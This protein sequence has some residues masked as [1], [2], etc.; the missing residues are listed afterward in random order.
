M[1]ISIL[2]VVSG[3]P[4]DRA[5]IQAGW[6]VEQMN[7]KPVLDEIDYQALSAVSRIR[8][9]LTL[10]DGERKSVLLRKE[11]WEPLGLVLDETALMKPR[12]CR[13]HCT[14][15][16]IDQ[17]PCRMRDSLYVKD[18]DWRLSLMMG[19]YITLT[20]IDDQEFSRIIRRKASPLYISVHATDP[21]VRLKLMRNPNADQLMDRL[22]QLKAHGLQ[23]HTQVV[24]CPGE[25][26]GEVLRK[27]I[28]DLRNLVPAALSLA[29]VPVGL[30]MHRKGLTPL[31][32]FNAK[33]A[34][35]LLDFLD[36]FQERYLR[37]IGTRFVFA[38][39]EFYCLSGRKIPEDSFYEGYPQIENGVGML[40]LLSEECAAAFE[41]LTPPSGYGRRKLLI[42]TGVSAFPVIRELAE[43]YAPEGT[44]VEVRPIT[45]RF[46]GESVTVTG[47]L[48]GRDLI[49]SLQGAECD[50]ILISSNMLRENQ[51]CFLDDLT[52]QDVQDALGKPIRVVS[53]TG[54]AF[55]SALYG[56]DG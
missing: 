15:C 34:G 29:I 28:Q 18:D 37:E 48:V 25:N 40:R 36:P 2:E 16:F 31:R 35:D 17:M 3:S 4:A 23:F 9:E 41:E 56:L 14:F 33:T 45:N 6:R 32:P 22:I 21:A 8:M 52:I 19:N 1:S 38:S 7:G 47:L 42:P 43:K 20:N 10:P 13:N 50:E 24:L 46:F 30:T 12:P 26:D 53:N 44:T 39:D 27:T 11:E 49:D 54:E 51:D 55:L 5:G